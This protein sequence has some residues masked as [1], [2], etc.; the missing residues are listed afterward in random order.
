VHADRRRLWFERAVLLAGLAAMLA[1]MLATHGAV[2]L[3]GAGLRVAIAL[4]VASASWLAWVLVGPRGD[5]TILRVLTACTAASGSVLLLLYPSLA[6]YW[7]TLWACFNAG[8]C[9]PTLVGGWL[10]QRD[11]ILLAFAA[12]AFVGYVFGRN[13]CRSGSAIPMTRSGSAWSTTV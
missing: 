12:V 6:V 7:F 4:A 8:V 1:A 10:D 5:T 13:R 3:H 2:S 9:F 11:T